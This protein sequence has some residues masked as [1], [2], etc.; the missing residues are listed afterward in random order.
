MAALQGGKSDDSGKGAAK[1]IAAAIQAGLKE[2]NG[3][4]EKPPEG[5]QPP[6]D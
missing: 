3:P 2:L 4:A 5:K 6:R 1:Q